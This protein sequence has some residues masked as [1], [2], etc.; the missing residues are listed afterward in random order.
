VI[1]RTWWG[2]LGLSFFLILAPTSSFVPIA[3]IAV[4]HR[5]YLPLIAVIAVVV[6]CAY[7]LL[8]RALHDKADAYG[9]L[10]L[11]VVAAVLGLHTLARNFDYRT[12]VA[13]WESVVVARPYNAR[14]WHNLGSALDDE[15]RHDEALACY[16]QVLKILPNYTPAHF[17]IGGIWLDR[18]DTDMAIERFRTA[19]QQDPDD[20][21]YHAHLGK[22]LMFAL[23]LDEAE[24]ELRRAIE[25][26]PKYG[27]SYEYLGL[28]LLG[29]KDTQ[30]AIEQ[31]RAGVQAAPNLSSNYHN[32][33]V[34]L[35][36]EGRF[37]EAV[38]VCNLALQRAREIK[39]TDE[40][41]RGFIERRDRYRDQAVQAPDE[42]SP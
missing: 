2:F 30:G 20:A 27:R 36:G 15:G 39:L 16:E 3:D 34:A 19:V 25:L 5:M 13:I 8:R 41:V 21:S 1:R 4:E 32:L 23:R 11:G 31:F 18:G 26:N 29:K 10:V 42:P 7:A 40:E 22:A 37:G 6:P 35:A 14:G 12:R 24:A 33:A 17:G 9:L 38:D 28:T